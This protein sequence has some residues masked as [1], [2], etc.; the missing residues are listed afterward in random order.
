VKSG[1]KTALGVGRQTL[2]EL[3]LF[4]E[5][6]PACHSPPPSVT[7]PAKTSRRPLNGA[8]SRTP[9][10]LVR[11]S[12]CSWT[13]RASFPKSDEGTRTR[14]RRYRHSIRAPE[15]GEQYR[16]YAII[17]SR[18]RA[19]GATTPWQI[20]RFVSGRGAIAARRSNNSSGSNTSSRVPSC[21]VR[22]NLIATRRLSATSS[23]P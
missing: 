15:G 8:G 17:R 6:R 12:R 19:R 1:L 9:L 16:P 14:R 20:S 23:L 22:F 21:Q 2:E 7:R 13:S 18:Q 4:A 11:R 3:G 5:R 10:P